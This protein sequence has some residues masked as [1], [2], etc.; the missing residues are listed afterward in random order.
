MM[1]DTELMMDLVSELK[2]G[3]DLTYSECVEEV[4]A[5]LE[6]ARPPKLADLL[7]GMQTDQEDED[8][9][10]LVRV[11]NDVADCAMNM[12]LAFVLGIMNE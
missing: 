7:A 1:L 12:S 6:A 11:C 9:A 10:F 2:G 8:A 3:R 5:I 4:V